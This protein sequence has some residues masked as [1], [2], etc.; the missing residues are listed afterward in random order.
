M[1]ALAAG[2]A[3]DCHLEPAELL[4]LEPGAEPGWLLAE[5]GRRIETLAAAAANT[6]RQPDQERQP[7]RRRSS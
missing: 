3:D 1:F 5:S 4:P 7:A 2:R 6:A